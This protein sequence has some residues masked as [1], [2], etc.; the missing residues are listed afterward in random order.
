MT[1]DAF[2]ACKFS[3]VCWG[4]TR[5]AFPAGRNG[6][7]VYWPHQPDLEMSESGLRSE[8]WANTLLRSLVIARWRNHDPD[9]VLFADP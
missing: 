4:S 5:A 8:F 3:G 2:A 7:R 1:G 6:G 9:P